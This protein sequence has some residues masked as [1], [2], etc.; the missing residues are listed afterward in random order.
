MLC[1]VYEQNQVSIWYL[2]KLHVNNSNNVNYTI[3]YAVIQFR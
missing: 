1:F 3:V 2:H